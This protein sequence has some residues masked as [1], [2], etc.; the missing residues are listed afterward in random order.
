MPRVAGG[1]I[2]GEAAFTPT[3]AAGVVCGV[4]AITAV[5]AALAALALPALAA[6]AAAA[7]GATEEAAPAAAP[8]AAAARPSVGAVL[9][10]LNIPADAA[11]AARNRALIKAK[12][13]RGVALALGKTPAPLP[14]PDASPASR[15]GAR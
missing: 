13:A 4:A 10:Q 9:Q 1:G 8:A 15:V 12:W 11:A 6:A 7:P 2:T 3:G 14:E 5:L